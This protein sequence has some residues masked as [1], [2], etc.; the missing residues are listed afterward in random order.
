VPDV[1]AQP[2][3]RVRGVAV[4]EQGLD[5]GQGGR[6]AVAGEVFP[7]QVLQARR[8]GRG[9][10]PGQRPLQPRP[11][12]GRRAGSSQFGTPSAEVPADSARPDLPRELDDAQVPLGRPPGRR[13]SSGFI[14]R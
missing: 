4:G 9:R 6:L 8:T 5:A 13:P 14:S 11:A 2:D 3:R 7:Q 1:Q 12:L 10:E